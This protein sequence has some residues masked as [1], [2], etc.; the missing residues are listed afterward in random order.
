VEAL[1]GRSLEL[2][3]Y[4]IVQNKYGF[5]V[6]GGGGVNR[7]FGRYLGWKI[8][9]ADYIHSQIYNGSNNRQNDLRL[10]TGVFF[11]IGPR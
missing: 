10:T 7:T 9:E 11:R 8:V 6:S 5:A 1:F 3:N 4:A 2:S